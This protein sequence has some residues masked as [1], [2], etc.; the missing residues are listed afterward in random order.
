[1][2]VDPRITNSPQRNLIGMRL[3]MNLIENRTVELWSKSFPKL[4][5]VKN[6]TSKD[7]ISL[8]N[9][10]KGYFKDFD[11][12]RN[13]EKWATVEVSEVTELPKEMEHFV[14][15]EGDYAVFDYKGPSNDSKIFQ[16]IF[17]EWLPSSP[18][19]LDNRPHFEVLGER[20]RSNDSNSEEEIWIP[21][22]SK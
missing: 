5:H 7:Y 15:G 16:Y 8:Q 12:T 3:S 19:E 4:S 21:I 10:P 11:P 6:R 13:F 14:L 17:N 20:Y 22:Q 2:K 18:Y 9:Y 1:M